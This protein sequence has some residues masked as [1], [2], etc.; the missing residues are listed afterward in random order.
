[1]VEDHALVQVMAQ[2]DAEVRRLYLSAHVVGVHVEAVEVG[3]HGIQR[4]FRL[5]GSGRQVE[6]AMLE[7]MSLASPGG[8]PRPAAEH[9]AGRDRHPGGGTDTDGPGHPLRGLP[10]LPRSCRSIK[11]ASRIAQVHHAPGDTRGPEAQTDL[12]PVVTT[13]NLYPFR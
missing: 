2:V 6:H 1:M 12:P 13:G 3:A 11:Y 5:D 4:V 10:P 7:G 8:R 9:H